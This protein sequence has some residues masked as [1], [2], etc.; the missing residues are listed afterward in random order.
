MK[1]LITVFAAIFLIFAFACVPASADSGVIY[2][3][4]VPPVDNGSL[5]YIDV[6]SDTGVSAA[7]LTLYFDDSF[8]VYRGI[9]AEK[10]TS[11]VRA[12]EKSGCVAFIFCDKDS[13]SGRLC[14]LTFRAECDGETE[15]LLSADEVLDASAAN[16][17]GVPDCVI[18]LSIEG[19]KVVSHS[20]SK[21]S[22]KSSK[23][24]KASAK[25]TNTDSTPDSEDVLL[26]ELTRADDSNSFLYGIGAGVGAVLFAVA[27]IIFGRTT[28]K[29][30]TDDDESESHEKEMTDEEFY[31]GD[32]K[33]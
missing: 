24:A 25:T 23:S 7:Q 4:C 1:R 28:V 13:V 30:P 15:L 33:E 16:V 26:R 3:E 12:S 9:S 22:S 27:C 17:Q 6:F 19:S 8:A 18:T 14:R 31:G 10:K 11:A 32:H 21:A 20:S 2:A 5:F 29:K